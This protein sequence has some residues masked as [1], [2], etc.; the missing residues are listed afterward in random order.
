MKIV[1]FVWE[2][3]WPV[4]LALLLCFAI[5]GGVE[6]Q[7]LKVGDLTKEQRVVLYAHLAKLRAESAAEYATKKEQAAK[8]RGAGETVKEVVGAVSAAIPPPQKVDEWTQVGANI[9]KG[10]VAAAKEI[11]TATVDFSKTDLG[12]ITVGVIVWKVI[13]RELADTAS[14]IVRY[15]THLFAS[16][17]FPLVWFLGTWYY[18]RAVKI[19]GITRAE[20]RIFS[21]VSKIDREKLTENEKVTF[22]M[23]GA[24]AF[25]GM[26]WALVSI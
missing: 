21:Y 1:E 6:A 17:L 4:L 7:T 10:L 20:G 9:G 22:V 11:G 15:F 24:I 5:V 18:I 25:I 2:A 16:L 12:K 8:L 19:T 14:G 13:G 3:T 26:V 23:S